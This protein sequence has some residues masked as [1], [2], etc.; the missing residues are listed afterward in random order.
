MRAEPDEPRYSARDLFDLLLAFNRDPRERQRMFK[1][2]LSPQQ[3]A[4]PLI[5]Q[6]IAYVRNQQYEQGMK[7]PAEALKRLEGKSKRRKGQM[8]GEPTKG[9]LFVPGDSSWA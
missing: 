5:V 3:H 8:F 9:E 6:F 7:D 1:Q 2:N 4:M